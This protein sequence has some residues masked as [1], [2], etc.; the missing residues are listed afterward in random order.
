MYF[1]GLDLAWGER[2]PT[3]V[4]VA[5]SRGRLVHLATATTDTDIVARLT[6][7]AEECLLAIDASLVV[8]NPSGNRPCEAALNRDFRRHCKY[9]QNPGRDMAQLHGE[10]LRLIDLVETLSRGATP[11]AW[12]R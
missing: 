9:K 12:G 1:A 2:S 3:G 8:S 4:A 5:D 10:L 11:D 6:C 7:T